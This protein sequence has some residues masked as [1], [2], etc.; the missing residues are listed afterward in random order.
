MKGRVTNVSVGQDSARSFRIRGVPRT[1]DGG[2][3]MSNSKKKNVVKCCVGCKPWVLVRF[4]LHPGEE[5]LDGFDNIVP[6][7][8]G[9]FALKPVVNK[10]VS[11]DDVRAEVCDGQHGQLLHREDRGARALRSRF[12]MLQGLFV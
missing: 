11:V 6:I 7:D 2:A 3:S 12:T 5:Q 4:A 10:S 8:D 9:I 1:A